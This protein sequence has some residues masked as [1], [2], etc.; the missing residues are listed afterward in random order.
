M[1]ALE[2]CWTPVNAFLPGS[3]VKQE[4]FNTSLKYA[5][6]QMSQNTWSWFSP[7]WGVQVVHTK[8]SLLEQVPLDMWLLVPACVLMCVSM[9]VPVC[10]CVFVSE[11]M[12]D[13]VCGACLYMCEHRWRSE[14]NLE[15][16]SSGVAHFVLWDEVTNWSLPIRLDTGLASE[17]QWH[18]CLHLPNTGIPNVYHQAPLFFVWFWGGFQMPSLTLA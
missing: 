10:I 1:S 9:C 15:F 8:V 14:V 13:Y 7:V 4:L 12:C 16:H 18:I 5:W 3:H 11:Y 6:A 2:A 17:S